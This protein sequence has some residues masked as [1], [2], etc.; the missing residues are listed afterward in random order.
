MVIMDAKSKV[1]KGDG[2]GVA[3][4]KAW[5]VKASIVNDVEII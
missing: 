4:S 5:K 3:E 2:T 1:Y